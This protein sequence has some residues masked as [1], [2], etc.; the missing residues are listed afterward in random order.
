MSGTR[1]L[2]ESPWRLTWRRFRKHRVALLAGTVLL[3]LGLACFGAP[4]VMDEQESLRLNLSEAK[5]PPS[6]EHPF[7]TTK[8]GR[9]YAVRC[10]YGGRISL[11][12]G[13]FA[14]LGAAVVVCSRFSVSPQT[15]RFVRR[16]KT[17][18]SGPSMAMDR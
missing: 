1:E 7:G 10:L 11:S 4:L 15:M 12:V 16:R 13:L 18:W 6:L 9:D 3:L 14:T 5:Q 2:V 17:A 8:L